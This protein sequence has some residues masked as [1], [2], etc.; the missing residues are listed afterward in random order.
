MPTNPIV[1]AGQKISLK[2]AAKWTKKYQKDHPAK[3][4]DGT[5]QD[6]TWATAFSRQYLEDFMAQWG[7]E[8]KGLRIYQATEDS[9]TRRVVLVAVDINGND[10]V[11]PPPGADQTDDYV[12]LD[13]GNQCPNECGVNSPLM[14]P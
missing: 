11:T 13:Q 7:D 6:V 3:A 1:T 14:L 12:V 5:T 9:G 10:I 2:E 8:C 4:E